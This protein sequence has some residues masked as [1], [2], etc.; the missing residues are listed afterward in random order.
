VA[1]LAKFFQRQGLALFICISF[2][3]YLSNWGY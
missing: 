2:Y 1:Q 3:C